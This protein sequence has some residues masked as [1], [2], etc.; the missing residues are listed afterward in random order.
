MPNTMPGA[1][2]RVRPCLQLFH[3]S[4]IAG[5][6]RTMSELQENSAS[7]WL[8]ESFQEKTFD[9]LKGS[10][11]GLGMRSETASQAFQPEGISWQRLR[12]EKQG[13]QR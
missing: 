11:G 6:M 2:R 8:Q 5:A 13:R 1:K 3:R 7:G 4:L 9:L 12:A 10:V